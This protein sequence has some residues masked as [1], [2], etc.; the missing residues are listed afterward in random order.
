[1]NG[2][3]ETENKRR[4]ELHKSALTK[5]IQLIEESDLK[6]SYIKNISDLKFLPI[7]KKS[8]N[9]EYETLYIDV[10]SLLIWSTECGISLQSI[11][12]DKIDYELSVYDIGGFKG[13]F[14]PPKHELVRYLNKLESIEAKSLNFNSF[15]SLFQKTREMFLCNEGVYDKNRNRIVDFNDVNDLYEVSVIP[16]NRCFLNLKSS[17]NEM[18]GSIF[19]F[20][21]ENKSFDTDSI[22]DRTSLI[23]SHLEDIK[24]EFS[25]SM[26]GEYGYYFKNSE[27]DNLEKSFEDIDG[28]GFN[29]IFYVDLEKVNWIIH[30][31][32]PESK[33]KLKN[34]ER[35]LERSSSY[36]SSDLCKEY[37]LIYFSY[38]RNLLR[39][40]GELFESIKT[41]NLI[42]YINNLH[43]LTSILYR[44][45]Q[46]TEELLSYVDPIEGLIIDE[47]TS[48]LESWS[49]LFHEQQNILNGYL[50]FDLTY[51][52]QSIKKLEVEREKL[53]DELY[54]NP[55]IL[56]YSFDELSQL[57]NKTRPSIALLSSIHIQQMEGRIR[58]AEGIQ[59]NREFYEKLIEWLKN[60]RYSFSH[61]N[62]VQR[63]SFKKQC[64]KELV[65]D[66]HANKWMEQWDKQHSYFLIKVNELLRLIF[67]NPYNFDRWLEILSFIFLYIESIDKFYLLEIIPIHQKHYSNKSNEL[68]EQLETDKYFSKIGIDLI[69]KSLNA[70]NRSH[71]KK[72]VEW[73]E[74]FIDFNLTE[75]MSLYSKGNTDKLSEIL[76][77]EITNLKIKNLDIFI[78]D[79][80]EYDNKVEEREKI[81]TSLM[82]R[83]NKELSQQG[84]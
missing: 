61:Y 18:M 21:K 59:D 31:H 6:S 33:E 39:D 77:S 80:K 73:L 35:Q 23:F 52:K 51:I 9:E 50:N 20:F 53:R 79:T 78:G 40:N 84:N 72:Y 71:D 2:K 14:I 12:I 65:D 44:S 34:I 38:T 81:F 82:Y 16:M 8:D 63:E 13:W 60:I 49:N 36:I 43:N 32:L 41:Y 27:I 30:Q 76:L 70:N 10:E 58:I 66:I 74:G 57:E 4:L 75:F 62:C 7:V 29:K 19:E 42:D 1:M 83:M 24:A 67:S 17:Q 68:L 28:Q 64:Q 26:F 15:S 56:S 55:N 54:S 69:K 22:F 3:I 25:F 5:K 37:D 11:A 45:Y 47:L 48:E 46:L